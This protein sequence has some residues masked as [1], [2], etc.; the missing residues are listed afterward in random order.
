MLASGLSS[1]KFSPG[2]NL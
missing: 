2:S 1:A